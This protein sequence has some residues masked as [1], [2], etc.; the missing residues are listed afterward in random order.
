MR[1]DRLDWPTTAEGEPQALAA[2]HGVVRRAELAHLWF[3]AT[4]ITV[5]DLRRTFAPLA[6]R[7]Q[8]EHAVIDTLVIDEGVADLA[9]GE[10]GETVIDGSSTPED[11]DGLA[12]GLSLELAEEAR[13]GPHPL[14]TCVFT[15]TPHAV[16]GWR[17]TGGRLAVRHPEPAWMEID[18][19]TDIG[20][21]MGLTAVADRVALLTEEDLWLYEPAARSWERRRPP[22]SSGLNASTMVAVEA[23]LHIMGVETG[24]GRGW[25]LGY[26]R[27]GGRVDRTETLTQIQPQDRPDRHQRK[28]L[29]GRRPA[30]DQPPAVRRLG[31]LSSRRRSLG[32]SRIPAPPGRQCRVHRIGGAALPVRRNLRRCSRAP[33][34]DHRSDCRLFAWSGSME[35]G[36]RP[37]GRP[38]RRGRGGDGGP[39][40]SV[41]RRRR[42]S[43]TCADGKPGHPP[44][45]VGSRRTSLWGEAEVAAAALNG[46]VYLLSRP[47]RDS[48]ELRMEMCAMETVLYLQE[49]AI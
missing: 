17:S 6:R 39:Y 7:R 42:R 20:P 40:P 13:T 47:L 18:T 46:A 24:S 28:A 26:A 1:G 12:V 49:A 41:R 23:R 19:P 11:A 8:S 31:G 27:G 25:H 22:P 43:Q 32:G 2:Q 5:K 16:R 35:I 48:G 29:R 44:P 45:G 4:E 37:S 30:P 36:S 21:W 10:G 9:D 15:R 14:E 38:P 3:H 33:P 34:L